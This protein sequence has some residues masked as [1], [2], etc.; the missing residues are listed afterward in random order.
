MSYPLGPV[1]WADVS[2]GFLGL[3]AGAGHPALLNLGWFW[4]LIVSSAL[5]ALA[6]H[7]CPMPGY[8]GLVGIGL[9][10]T[11]S[12]PGLPWRAWREDGRALWSFRLAPRSL[13]TREASVLV[14]LHLAGLGLTLRLL[15]WPFVLVV[16]LPSA[17]GVL[18]L[19]GRVL[20]RPPVA[21]ALN[22]LGPVYLLTGLELLRRLAAGLGRQGAVGCLFPLGPAL[23]ILAAYA[24]AYALYGA[25][26][27]ER[28]QALAWL[29]AALIAGAA[30][31]WAA[32]AYLT[33]YARGVTGSDPFCYVQMAIDWMHQGTLLHRF[34]LIPLALRLGIDPRPLLFVGYH[35]DL[36]ATEWVP[37]V[38]PGGHSLLL[39]LAGRLAGETAIYLGTPLVALV[40]LIA[41]I[42]LGVVLFVDLEA[43]QRW[44][45]ASLAGLLLGTSF[46]QM[47]WTLVHMADISAQLFSILTVLLAW[48]GIARSR[49]GYIGAAGLALALAYGARHTQLAMAVPVLAFF[50]VMG[51]KRYWRVR[52]LDGMV[53]LGAAF[54]GALPDLAYHQALF[55]SPLHPESKELALYTWRAVPATTLLLVK[56]WLAGPEFGYL[57]PFL[58]IGAW[59]L[60][61]YH[62]QA[63]FVL[64]L[65][66]GALWAVQAAYSSLRL[67]DLLPALP[68]LALLTGYGV[69]CSLRWLASR[70]RTGVV[71]LTLGIGALLWLRTADTAVRPLYR[72]F[73]NFGFLWA[74]QRQE[75]AAVQQMTE[76]SAVIGSTLNSGPLALYGG[77]E[78][79]RP[80]AWRPEE[81]QRFL[82]ALWEE[83]RP[84][85]L[86]VDGVE[87]GPV[88]A[89]VQRYAHLTPVGVLRRV[90]YYSPDGGSEIRDALL[91][92]LT[93]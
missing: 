73:N 1:G 29:G 4:Q 72:S 66:L 47:R 44:L 40:S 71:L 19:L 3:S 88:L 53:Y 69:A 18:Q 75:F 89:G 26:P 67:R 11:V 24:F 46:E 92:R 65:W 30:F 59:G 70:W 83:G 35:E 25:W 93:R 54:L 41:V 20:R 56:G 28:R 39:G 74:T 91:Y 33:L 62:R 60:W 5:I 87:M 80:A 77:R 78:T 31:A 34:P 49:R 42:G 13:A 57:A 45:A 16:I 76:E 85:Y 81:L 58:L 64:G 50:L 9:A 90:P 2:S 63:G 82:Q 84:T 21:L 79:F 68:A 43:P 27:L 52:L 37:T 48:Q 6:R 36:V 17:L 12:L 22:A 10:L 7:G 23:V 51:K 86:L 15:H 14:V 38:W 32:W 61:R 55:G 8:S